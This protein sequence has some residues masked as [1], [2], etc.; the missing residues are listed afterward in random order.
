[1]KMKVSFYTKKR[2]VILVAENL[3]IVPRE[4]EG[5]CIIV[6][7]VRLKGKVQSVTHYFDTVTPWE[8]DIFVELDIHE[9]KAIER[10]V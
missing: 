5:I 1:M 9:E 7:S 8:S 3:G 10:R 4:G 2:S 6:G